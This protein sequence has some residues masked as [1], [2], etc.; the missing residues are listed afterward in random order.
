[1][2]IVVSFIDRQGDIYSYSVI[3]TVTARE[4]NLAFKVDD[5]DDA[6]E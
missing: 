1:M 5:D 2:S 6:F 4:F 3:V